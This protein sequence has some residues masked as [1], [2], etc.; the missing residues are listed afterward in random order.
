MKKLLTIFSLVTGFVFFLTACVTTEV[1]GQGEGRAEVMY[2]HSQVKQMF[3][4]AYQKGNRSAALKVASPQ[5]VRKLTWNG[6]PEAF[7][8]GDAILSGEGGFE[9]KMIIYSDGHVGANISDVIVRH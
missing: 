9:I 7:L 1:G 6:D 5:A 4:E 8:E 3:L 2:D